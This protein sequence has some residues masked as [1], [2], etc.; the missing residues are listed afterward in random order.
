MW[1]EIAVRF[2][3]V[4][5][6]EQ[7]SWEWTLYLYVC[8]FFLALWLVRHLA[9]CC[10]FCL[11]K[12]FFP[13]VLYSI[14]FIF[15]LCGFTD[16]SMHRPL[17]AFLLPVLRVNTLLLRIKGKKK[18]QLVVCL[19]AAQIIDYYCLKNL[20]PFWNTVWNSHNILWISNVIISTFRGEEKQLHVFSKTNL[21]NS[22]QNY[23]VII[24]HKKS[25]T[26]SSVKVQPTAVQHN[27]FFKL[28]LKHTLFI[29]YIYICG[30]RTVSSVSLLLNPIVSFPFFTHGKYTK[31]RKPSTFLSIKLRKPLK[32]Q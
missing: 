8:C 12:C 10:C 22:M 28:R 32:L 23:Y 29:S 13:T 11:K 19:C 17:Y 21:R 3:F 16:T 2:G 26:L 4:V 30:I 14:L 18:K 27:I 5:N 1:N 15:L 24:I 7:R 20:R 25:L 6:T 31:T 9:A